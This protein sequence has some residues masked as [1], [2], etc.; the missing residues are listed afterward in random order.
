MSTVLDTIIADKRDHVAKARL[1]RPLSVIET[2]A[3]EA[4]SPR[5]FG[6]HLAR[7]AASGYG[8][9][10]EIKKASPSKGLIRN[11][12]NPAELASAY[13]AGGATCLSVLTDRPY[14][15]GHDT[16]LVAA[17]NA[18]AL[19]VLRKDFMIDPYQIVESRA[20]GADC[21]LIIMAAVD[22]SLAHTLLATARDWGMDALVEVHDADEMARALKMTPDLI[23]IN[24]RNLKTLSVDLATTE[25]LA[26]QVPASTILVSE[27]GLNTRADLDRMAR[28]GARCFLIGESFMRQDDVAGAVRN[29]L[30]PTNSGCDRDSRHGR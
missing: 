20:L 5:G 9:I 16:Y 22:D 25:A 24:N 1:R 15:Q 2:T 17:R 28:A 12:F 21:I 11:D 6:E 27:S 19:P 13:D 4:E 23:G 10:C 7:R 29:I 26:E 3:R 8:L 18:V 14:F 30:S